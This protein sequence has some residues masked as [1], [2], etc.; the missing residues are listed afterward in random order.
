MSHIK[1]LKGF[2]GLI[3]RNIGCCSSGLLLLLLIGRRSISFFSHSVLLFYILICQIQLSKLVFIVNS[4][5]REFMKDLFV[6]WM[7]KRRGWASIF[8]KILKRTPIANTQ[9]IV[10]RQICQG[11]SQF[12][13]IALLLSLPSATNLFR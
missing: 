6:L 10:L 12:Q 4:F 2:I 7:C 5:C 11:C 1:I 13:T 8:C 9:K 3:C